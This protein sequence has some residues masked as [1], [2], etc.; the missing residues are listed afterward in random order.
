MGKNMKNKI[1][2]LTTDEITAISGGFKLSEEC[3]AYIGYA[4]G[5]VSLVLVACFWIYEYRAVDRG[6]REY[7]EMRRED[8]EQYI[9]IYGTQN[10]PNI[11]DGCFK[12]G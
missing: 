10:L 12:K 4:V 1:I 3:K 7:G 2:E 11:P 8:H 9:R 5:A 6:M